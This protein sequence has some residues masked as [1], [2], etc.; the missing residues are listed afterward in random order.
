MIFMAFVLANIAINI[1]G[2]GG[3]SVAVAVGMTTLLPLIL[4]M[5]SGCYLF[6]LPYL[7]KRRRSAD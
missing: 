2:A 4:L 3:E 1:T 6:A 5:L 7:A